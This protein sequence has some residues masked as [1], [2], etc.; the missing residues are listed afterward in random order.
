M[1]FHRAAVL[2]DGASIRRVERQCDRI[3]RIIQNL[4]VACVRKVA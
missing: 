2:G 1:Q 3:D 4:L